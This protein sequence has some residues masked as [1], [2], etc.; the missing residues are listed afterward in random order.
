MFGCMFG[1]PDGLVGPEV[2]K[3]D[4]RNYLALAVKELERVPFRGQADPIAVF[5]DERLHAG[6]GEGLV[7]LELDA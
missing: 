1:P 7:S 5:S 6:D 4:M 3:G 2:S